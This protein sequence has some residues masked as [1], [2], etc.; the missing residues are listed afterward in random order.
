LDLAC[1]PEEREKDTLRDSQSQEKI[2][3]MFSMRGIK[4]KSPQL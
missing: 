1:A 3:E 4:Q 2:N